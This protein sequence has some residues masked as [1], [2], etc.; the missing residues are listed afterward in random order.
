MRAFHVAALRDLAVHAL[1]VAVARTASD[2]GFHAVTLGAVA[3]RPTGWVES[4]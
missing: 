1:G 4:E 3:D 2:L